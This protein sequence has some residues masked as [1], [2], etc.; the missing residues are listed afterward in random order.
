MKRHMHLNL[1]IHSRGHH[2]AAWRHPAASPLA[3]SDI[4]Y[5]Q[6]LAQQAEAGLFDAIFLADQL[7]LG[8]DIAYGPR[9]ALEPITVLAALAVSTSH[10]GLIAT[11]S[12]TYTEPFNLARQF[13][14]LDHISRGRIGWNI[15][16]SW[17][18][19]AARNY[20]G[21]AQMSH[22]ERYARAEEFMTVVKGLWDSWAADAE[23]DDR[24]GGRYANPER[25]RPINHEGAYYRVAGPLNLPRCPQ[26]R[27]VLVQAG[28]SDTGRSFAARHAEAIF[29]AQVEKTS[30]Q[31]FYADLKARAACAGRDP[32]QV[33]ILPGF[34][35]YIA[36]SASAAQRLAEELRD[37]THPEA[38]RKRLSGRFGG[39]DFSHLP[40]DR[41][42]TP[43]DFPA[44]S[45]V[46]AARSRTEVILDLVRRTQPTLRQLLAILAGARG[47]Y[48]CIGTPEQIADLMEDWFTT[49]AADG[50]N[51]MPP[52]LPAMLEVFIAE[53]VPLLQRRGL[54]RTAYEGAT[55]RAH[56]GLA[57]PASQF[58]S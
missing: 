36:A 29:T 43:D 54:F 41:P 16:T 35:P 50:F 33:L 57:A 10:L 48:T 24:V 30:A 37:L 58:D 13:A 47:H 39:H 8:D 1:F 52:V 44:P 15:V 19:P 11:A 42:L 55:L 23:L 26:G 12:T 7:A 51:I 17:L 14:S 21:T 2:E 28:S 5:Y 32:A 22:A 18:A 46:E 31:A 49:G 20:G 56:Y 27:P 40:L 34:S 38:G 3:L 6:G 9:T 25:I 4:R 45:S 53:V